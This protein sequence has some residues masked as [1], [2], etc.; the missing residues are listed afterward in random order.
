MNYLAHA[1]LSFND[2]EILIGNLI[3]DC[4]KGKQRY[5]FPENVQRGIALHRKID[6]YTDNHPVIKEIQKLY[7]LSAGRYNGVFLDVTFDHFL[8]IDSVNEPPEG[9]QQFSAWCYRQIDESINDTPEIFRRLFSYMKKE[10]WLYNYRHKWMMQRSFE[11]LAHRAKFLPNSAD[12]YSDFEQN[13]QQLQDG[14]G[15][16]FPELKLFVENER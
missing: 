4:V 7:T 8:A 6:E 12:I 2:P 13:Y 15:E 9:W 11:R 16:F 5:D 1:Y 10:N 14:Y 3:A